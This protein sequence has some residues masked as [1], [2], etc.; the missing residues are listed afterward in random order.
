MPYA[1]EL[2]IKYLQVAM[3]WNLYDIGH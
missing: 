1:K 2:G 3:G